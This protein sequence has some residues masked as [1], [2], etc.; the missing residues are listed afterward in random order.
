[1]SKKYISLT[2]DFFQISSIFILVVT[3]PLIATNILLR[4]MQFVALAIILWAVWEMKRTRYYRIPDIGKQNELVKTG[5]YKYI[6]NPM[7]FSELL[8]TGALVVN[9]YTP[10]RLVL[11]LILFVDFIFKIRYEEKLLLKYFKEKFVEYKKNS[12]RLLPFIY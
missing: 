11:F 4:I 12:W 10:L 5:V 8:F 2:M 9:S 3:G 6:R 1:M 7:Y